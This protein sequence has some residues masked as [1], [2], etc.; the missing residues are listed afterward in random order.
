VKEGGGEGFELISS[1]N[2]VTLLNRT[3][4]EKIFFVQQKSSRLFAAGAVFFARHFLGI[5]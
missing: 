2:K 3:M 1:V 4:L 5:M